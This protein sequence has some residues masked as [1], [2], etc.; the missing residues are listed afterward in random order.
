MPSTAGTSL[1]VVKGVVNAYA[2]HAPYLP[3]FFAVHFY[4]LR[5]SVATLP[6]SPLPSPFPLSLPLPSVPLSRRIPPFSFHPFLPFN[7]SSPSLFLYLFLSL[8]FSQS[9]PLP[10]CL[11]WDR[12]DFPGGGSSRE[13]EWR[14]G[15]LLLRKKRT[16]ASA[17][18]FLPCNPPSHPTPSHPLSTL[19]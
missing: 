4:G 1:T 5:T 18:G 2:T 17:T 12:F 13:A 14:E 7:P 9:L 16:M 6:P 11:L 8:P 19:Q 15:E 3:L 10:L